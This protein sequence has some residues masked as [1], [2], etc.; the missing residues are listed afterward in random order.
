[1]VGMISPSLL[2][3]DAAHTIGKLIGSR[4]DAVGRPKPNTIVGQFIPHRVEMI[5]STA[6]G[7]LSHAAR[8]VLDRLECEHA[9]HGGMENGNLPCTYSDFERFG[10]RRKS[11]APAIAELVAA[12]FLEVTVKGR[13]GNAAYRNSSRYR[14]TY[15]ATKKTAPTDDWK[16]KTPGAKTPLTPGAKT[17]PTD[18]VFGGENA[19]TVSGAKTPLLSISRGEPAHIADVARGGVVAPPQ[20]GRVSVA[21]LAGGVVPSPEPSKIIAYRMG[22]APPAGTTPLGPQVSTRP[23]SEGGGPIQLSEALQRILAQPKRAG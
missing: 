23:Y 19:P 12:G 21:E 1:M 8:R 20:K 15:L 7:C 6:Y 10:L 11:I 4:G 14:L 18:R 2:N 16:N 9:G 5:E 3:G 22:E 17:P 13:G